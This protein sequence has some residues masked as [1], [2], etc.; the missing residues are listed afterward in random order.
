MIHTNC[1]LSQAEME[2]ASAAR[3]RQQLIE[4]HAGELGTQTGMHEV[5]VAGLEAHQQVSNLRACNNCWY[6]WR[7]VTRVRG[8]QELQ[9]D[10][11]QLRKALAA[12]EAAAQSIAASEAAAHAEE[13]QAA[14][15]ACGGAGGGTRC[16]STAL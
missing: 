3:E 9:K 1:H 6:R 12:H 7:S 5:V 4:A 8:A 15:C 13:L 2:C 14:N 10:C 16:I 11:T